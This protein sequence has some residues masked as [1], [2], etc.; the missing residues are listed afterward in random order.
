[1]KEIIWY[2]GLDGDYIPKTADS[3]EV[4]V[5]EFVT[6]IMIFSTLWDFL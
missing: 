5:K 6:N 4:G 3:P 2:L 1:M